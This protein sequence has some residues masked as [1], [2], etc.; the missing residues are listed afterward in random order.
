MTR[1]EKDMLIVEQG[2]ED[3]YM[4]MMRRREI[5]MGELRMRLKTTRNAFITQCTRQELD[6]EEANYRRLALY[7]GDM[8]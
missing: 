1:L 6:R 3:E 7:A 2:S 4:A 5:R 8:V